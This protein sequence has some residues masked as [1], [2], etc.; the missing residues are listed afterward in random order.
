MKI[1]EL[2]TPEEALVILKKLAEEN[3]NICAEIERVANELRCE[4]NP[5]KIAG[6]VF[7]ELNSIA[8]EDV[9]DSSGNT[10]FGYI[11]PGERAWEMVEEVLE[12]YLEKMR[13]YRDMSMALEERIYCMGILKGLY[14]YEKESDSEFRNW[15]DDAPG[16]YFERILNNWIENCTQQDSVSEMKEFVKRECPDWDQIDYKNI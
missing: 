13:K 3:K 16:E 12:Y 4:I 10:G 15:A 8:V 11:E 5:D 2:L 7:S 14:R 9:W 6:D 1:T